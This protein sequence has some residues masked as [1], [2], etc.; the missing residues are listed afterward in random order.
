M[1]QVHPRASTER[2]PYRRPYRRPCFGETNGE[3]E[4]MTGSERLLVGAACL[5]CWACTGVEVT[6]GAYLA[7][8]ERS[9]L[10]AP[11]LHRGGGA[12]NE[13]ASFRRGGLI[14]SEVASLHLPLRTPSCVRAIRRLSF[15]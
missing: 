6:R 1:E 9:A 12:G 8:Y 13:C 5:A 7:F 2:R 14:S 11:R 15:C 3:Q 10:S 4:E